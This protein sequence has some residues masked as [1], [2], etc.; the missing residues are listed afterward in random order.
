MSADRIVIVGAGDSGTRAALRVR[1]LDQQVRITLIGEETANPYER[2]PLTKAVL[3]ENGTAP[4]VIATADDLVESGIDWWSGARAVR[5][6]SEAHTVELEDGRR[7]GYERLLIATGAR[8]RRLPI[9]EDGPSHTVRS[10][11]DASALAS[12]LSSKPDLLIVGGGFIGLETAASARS[13]GA[14]VTVVEFA[15]ELMSRVVPASV[16]RVI[17]DRHL[18]EGVDLRTGVSAQALRSSDTGFEVDLD[19]GTTVRGD[20]LVV[21][22]G[23]IPNVE[24]A[25]TAGLSIANG[26]AV[27]ETLRTS[28]PDIFAAG[29]CCSVPHPLY[30]GQ[31]IRL[32]AWRNAL[33]QAEV[34]AGNLLGARDVYDAVPSFWS[35]QY[36]LVM[37]AVGLHA[38]AAGHV[39]RR[40]KDGHNLEFGLDVEGRIVSA[41]GVA[42]GTTLARDIAVATRL[43][44]RRAVPSASDLSDP[45]VPLRSLA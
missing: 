11:G 26:I 35:D 8:A 38:L 23:A 28:D 30:N 15:H 17:R 4:P 40:G 42:P 24:L 21:G 34:V 1:E 27:D 33:A 14:T 2:P 16:A 32:E 36:D 9:A 31:R 37:N 20:V 41:S 3:T 10:L 43:I 6:D 5:V 39:V 7:V 13:V 19:D 12:A 18:S 29:D 25:A 22:I 45:T 44:E